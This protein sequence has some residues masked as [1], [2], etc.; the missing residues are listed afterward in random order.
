MDTVFHFN[1]EAKLA[2]VVTSA[3]VVDNVS[4][5]TCPKHKLAVRLF[6]SALLDMIEELGK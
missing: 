5:P 2:R 3:S 6:S 4:L 1:H